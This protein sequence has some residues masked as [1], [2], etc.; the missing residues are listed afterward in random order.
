MRISG[1]GLLYSCTLK[2][3]RHSPRDHRGR[4]CSRVGSVTA[5]FRAWIR[6]I[7]AIS[8]HPF[9]LLPQSAFGLGDADL[10]E[11]GFRKRSLTP[12]GTFQPNSQWKTL[13][14]QAYSRPYLAQF[15]AGPF[16][17][18]GMLKSTPACRFVSSV[19]CRS[20]VFSGI[21]KVRPAAASSS[22]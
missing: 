1:I 19:A 3:Q 16:T 10:C 18:T 21:S 11:R 9:R 22:T 6:V 8:D 20:I 13:A 17:D 7:G 14:I 4:I 12:R 2:G 15:L 5:A